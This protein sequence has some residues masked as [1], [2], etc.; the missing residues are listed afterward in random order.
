MLSFFYGIEVLATS[1]GLLLSHQKYV[2]DL[3]SKQ[4]M[5]DSKPVS[6]PLVIG[7]SLTAT[8]GS[9]PVNGTMYC[10]VIGGLQHLR[11]TRPDISFTMNKLSQFMYEPSE[12][13]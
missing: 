13:H 9:T 8:D 5:L 3:L 12:N 11:M 4:N 1:T 7:P 6:T 10:Q 2:I